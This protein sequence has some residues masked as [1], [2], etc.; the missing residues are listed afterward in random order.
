MPDLGSEEKAPDRTMI[1]TERDPLLSSKISSSGRP[2]VFLFVLISR[3]V[4]EGTRRVISLPR[5]V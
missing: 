5:E 2:P 1:L 4:S 3:W